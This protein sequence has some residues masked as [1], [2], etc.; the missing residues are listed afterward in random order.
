[1]REEEER[2]RGA[3]SKA[4]R[5]TE[6]SEFRTFAKFKTRFSPYFPKTQ[7]LLRQN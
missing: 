2:E 1:V 6:Y 3:V 5:K 4:L 7:N